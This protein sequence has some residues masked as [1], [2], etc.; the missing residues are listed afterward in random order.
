MAIKI[1]LLGILCILY[2]QGHCAPFGFNR[3]C[4]SLECLCKKSRDIGWSGFSTPITRAGIVENFPRAT[5]R[6]SDSPLHIIP[7]FIECRININ[8]RVALQQRKANVHVCWRFNGSVLTFFPLMIQVLNRNGN[9]KGN[10]FPGQ[11]FPHYTNIFKWTMPR[12]KRQR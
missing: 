8:M 4:I 2:R 7:N 10:I 9:F 1:S 11:V 12:G 5:Q 3:W 6:S